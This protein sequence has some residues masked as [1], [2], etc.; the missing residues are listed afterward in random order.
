MTNFLTPSNLLTVAEF[1]SLAPTVDVSKYDA[2]TLSGLIG[3]ASQMAS[4]FLQYTP[5]A[6]DIVNEVVPRGLINSEGDLMVYPN[7][8][9][10][11]RVDAITIIKGSVTLPLTLLNGQNQQ[12]Y[13]VD[14]SGN[15]LRYPYGELSLQG[16]PVFIDFYALRGYQFYVEFSYRGGFEVAQLPLSIKQAVVLYM[17][18]IISKDYN[19]FGAQSVHQGG[20]GFSYATER[21]GDSL[22]IV[23]AKRLLAP[24]RRV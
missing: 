5:L 6:E 23:Q 17:R 4:D 13:N 8:I 19:A 20:L 14:R 24:Y 16:V 3:Q 22:F 15:Y 18:D 11:Q 7:K 2:P 10:I 1:K 9:P 21:D 12:K